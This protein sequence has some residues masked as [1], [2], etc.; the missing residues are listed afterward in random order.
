M[1]KGIVHKF[2]CDMYRQYILI[3]FD[4]AKFTRMT[5]IDMGPDLAGGCVCQMDNSPLI[6]WLDMT[7]DG[8][9]DMTDCAHESFHIADLMLDMVG[10]EYTHDTGN[11]H[12]AY[13]IGWTMGCVLEAQHYEKVNMGLVDK[14][15]NPIDE[16][17]EGFTVIELEDDEDIL[18]MLERS[19]DAW[20]KKCR[21]DGVDDEITTREDLAKAIELLNNDSQM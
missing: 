6:M 9:L 4:P 14:Q 2:Y 19:A 12:I 16:P 8:K 21:E 10:M 17:S 7:E 11:E 1:L 20:D 18:D 15:G 5:T 13:L 3:T